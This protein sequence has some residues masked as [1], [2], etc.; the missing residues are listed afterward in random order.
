MSLMLW[1]RKHNKKIM[2]FVVI[3]LMI[4][5]TIQPV[6]DYLSWRRSG[7]Q[8]AFAY[9]DG[10]KKITAN[11]R[12][13]AQK[14]LGLLKGIGADYFLRPQDPRYVS[15]QDLQTA[16]LGELLFSERA[17][18]AQYIERVRRIVGM[19]G[20]GLTEKQIN[21]I[22][23]RQYSPDIYWL[24]LTAEAR[25]AGIRIP[26]ETAKEQLEII[27]PRMQRGKT[28]QQAISEIVAR[29]GASEEQVVETFTDLISVIQNGKMMCEIQAT[30]SQQI[31]H[32]IDWRRESIDFS[33]VLFD[34]SDFAAGVPQPGQEKTGG[35]FSRY[36]GFFAGDVN[37]DNPYGF[38]YKLPE[39]VGLEY[40]AV[41]LDD[42]ASTIQQPTQQETEEYYQQH[43]QYFAQQVPSDPNDPNSRPIT[44]I[45]GYAEVANII[46][47]GLY[48]QRV[49]SKAEQILQDA[50]TI[51]EA[52]QPATDNEQNRPTD[53]QMKQSAVDYEKTAIHLSDK[54]NI[55]VYAGKTGL[56]G[57][58][59]MQSDPQLGSLYLSG[60]GFTD[61]G[62][63][64][65]VFA[66]E[67][68]KASELGPF[69]VK[70]PRL[71]ENIGPLRDAREQTQGY[72]G[73]NM[74]LVRATGAEKAAEPESINDKIYRRTA[75]LG[76][77]AATAEDVNTVRDEVIDDLRAL[78]GMETARSRVNEF[79]KLAAKNGWES[80]IDKFNEHYGRV[81]ANAASDIQKTFTLQTRKGIR[82]I[83]DEDMAM[84]KLRYEGDPM[85]R[86]LLSRAKV[87]GMLINKFY[88]LLP[89]DVNDLNTPGSIVEF[90]PRKC[91]YCLNNLTIHRLYQDQFDKIK[92]SDV[93][94][95]V[96]AEA[97]VLAAT[98]YGPENILKRMK[99]ELVREQGEAARP[100]APVQEA[101][102]PSG[103]ADGNRTDQQ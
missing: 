100:G 17:T 80:A 87:E 81:E 20:Y 89:D 46:S 43:L 48:H 97:Q 27:I 23:N 78:A 74:M 95:G 101:N 29:E 28:Y 22:Y 40:I 26:P 63:V 55:K 2:A 18:A 66:V 72:S 12:I 103:P 4:V 99:F 30:T 7:G 65:V 60:T 75:T 42:I 32:E 53:E 88:A 11:D 44:R 61:A 47:K 34:S 39:R 24:L 10:H 19:A 98:Q 91:Y 70:P 92:A 9:Y 64:K 5:F 56:M 8:G 90:K 49:A 36:K 15:S 6:M 93:M 73:R 25:S 96:F 85:I 1:F 77:Q 35:Q 51:T 41:R 69:D 21:D 59:D 45:R 54:Y 76:L 58:V 82:R 94:R 50:K 102:S 67:Q 71:Y 62:L 16:F 37:E 38:G 14:Q 84:L 79:V 13:Q 57:A 3:A 52:N 68:L 33:Y 83:T 86:E 31:L